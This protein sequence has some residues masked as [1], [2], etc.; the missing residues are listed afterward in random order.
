MQSVSDPHQRTKA[1]SGWGFRIHLAFFIALGSWTEVL[2]PNPNPNT[3]Y[4][5]K[6]CSNVE[7]HCRNRPR[8]ARTPITILN[9]YCEYQNVEVH[10]N[11][12][13]Q[14]TNYFW[15]VAPLSKIWFFHVSFR[16]L[17]NHKPM[18]DSYMI[19]MF[20]VKWLKWVSGCSLSP[21][22]LLPFVLFVCMLCRS[23]TKDF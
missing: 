17:Q 23:S 21:F 13:R 16:C 12:H 6:P 9:P 11:Y 14:H 22:F 19:R 8:F 10:K 15:Q 7:K 5:L 4:S 18:K 1:F 20:F 2:S 3:K